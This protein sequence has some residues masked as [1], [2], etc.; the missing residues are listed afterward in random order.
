MVVYFC[1][2]LV[3]RK[4]PSKIIGFMRVL[5]VYSW[6]EHYSPGSEAGKYLSNGQG[7]HQNCRLWSCAV[8]HAVGNVNRH[9]VP[10]S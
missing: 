5:L 1:L 4:I 7:R 3:V 10:L 6:H 2:C 8:S 9:S